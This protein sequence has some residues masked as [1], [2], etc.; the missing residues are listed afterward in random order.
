MPADYR[1]VA[2]HR[3]VFSRASGDLTFA[4]CAAHMS[5]LSNDPQFDPA[6]RQIIDF[7]EAS[8][9]DLSNDQIRRLATRT[10]FAADSRRAFVVS[11]DLQYGLGRVFGTHRE[12]DGEAPLGIF[13]TLADAV[14]WLEI[15]ATVAAEAFAALRTQATAAPSSRPPVR[16]T[17]PE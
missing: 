2:A 6:F 10:I 4:D 11:S 17:R 16:S 8:L 15:P 12:L 1:V 9:V 3:I 7:T 5:R 13:R 14:A